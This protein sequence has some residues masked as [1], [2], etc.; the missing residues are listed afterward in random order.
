M[1]DRPGRESPLENLRRRRT[2]S[3][4]TTLL[5]LVAFALIVVIVFIW[6][7]GVPGRIRET[8]LMTRTASAL[9]DSLENHHPG[10][11]TSIDKVSGEAGVREEQWWKTGPG[12]RRSVVE[13]C[14]RFR[15]RVAGDSEVTFFTDSI[16]VKL[17]SYRGGVL[18]VFNFASPDEPVAGPEEADAKPLPETGWQP[19]DGFAA[20]DVMPVLLD[21]PAPE[22]PDYARQAE[23]EGTVMIKALV[24]KDGLVERA[25]IVEGHSYLN[26]PALAAAKQAK[27]KPALQDGLP[28]AV[29][30][31][32]PMRFTLGTS[33]T[34]SLP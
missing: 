34:E 30:V 24:G 6:Y 18:A 27:F 22:Y 17:C 23:V 9:I 3:E 1:T 12:E 20:V 2:S 32:I 15:G 26:D 29:W 7:L 16:W 25:S 5:A 33:E 4:R 28:V 31:Q 13:A 11:V 14:S 21:L 19:A 10:L 8:L